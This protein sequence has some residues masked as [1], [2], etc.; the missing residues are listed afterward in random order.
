MTDDAPVIEVRTYRAVSGGR[1]ESLEILRSEGQREPLKTAVYGGAEWT[2][3][4]E[5]KIMP[6]LESY[7]AVVVDD[8]VGCATDAGAVILGGPIGGGTDVQSVQ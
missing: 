3:D 8:S 5:A 7:G 4:L 6:L 1:D 2:S